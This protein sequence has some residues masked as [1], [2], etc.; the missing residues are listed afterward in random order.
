MYPAKIWN[1]QLMISTYDVVICFCRKITD[2]LVG[3]T[4]PG[5]SG[6]S[7]TWADLFKYHI[8]KKKMPRTKYTVL[9]TSRIGTS[10]H[11]MYEMLRDNQ[12]VLAPN[13]VGM[14]TLCVVK[15]RHSKNSNGDESSDELGVTWLNRAKVENDARMKRFLYDDA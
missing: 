15:F 8:A 4:K 6:E 11:G 10:S 14:N 1:K 9:D 2:K 12:R 5:S 3:N 13:I 7:D